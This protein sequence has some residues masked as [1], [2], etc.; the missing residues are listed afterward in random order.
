MIDRRSFLL[1]VFFALIISLSAAGMAIFV[2]S[3]QGIK[4]AY[5]LSAVASEIRQMSPEGYDERHLI[6]AARAS[7]LER[8][9]RYSGYMDKAQFDMLHQEMSGGYDGLGITVAKDSLGLMIVAVRENGPAAKAGLHT[10]DLILAADSVNL[11]NKSSLEASNMLRGKEGTSVN[12]TIRKAGSEDSV[13]LA[14]TR[15]RIPL[16]HIPFAGFTPDS[17]IYIRLL[18]FESGASDDLKAA[19]DTLYTEE[20]KPSTRGIILDLRSN[21]GGLFLEAR[22]T[23]DLF[24]KDGVKIVGTTGRSRWENE[25]YFASGDDIIEGL[26]MAVIVDRGSA[27]SSE[28]V[29]GALQQAGRAMLVGDTTFGKGLV[30]GF[31]RFPDGDGLRLT[32]SRYYVGD[33][34]YLNT[35]DSVL[36]EVGQGLPPDYYYEYEERH[37]SLFGLERSL[38]PFRFA[39]ENK[40]EIIRSEQ[41]SPEEEKWIGQFASYAQ[42]NGFIYHSQTSDELVF[43]EELARTISKSDQLSKRITSLKERSLALDSSVVLSQREYLSRRLRQLA[44]QY[45]SGEYEAYRQ[46]IVRQLPVIRYA[47]S[48]LIGRDD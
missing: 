31:V 24:L 39:E 16:L 38:L 40:D 8:L 27:S 5:L 48:L 47:S 34:L 30:Q 19:I 22:K 41:G 1:T 10:G 9:D 44:I 7:M 2:L 25:D 46:V 17:L 3:D 20:T 45:D 29:A 18:D 42:K 11:S 37:P 23:A 28:I 21:P 33:S 6:A 35:F 12:L 26:P 43:F 4:D 13:E 14:I 32:I 15:E 36:N